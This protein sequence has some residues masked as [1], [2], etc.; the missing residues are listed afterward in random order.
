[1]LF[2]F[3]GL[4][5][6]FAKTWLTF[7]IASVP[8]ITGNVWATIRTTNLMS[9]VTLAEWA[10]LTVAL[11]VVGCISQLGMKPGYM[12]EV[13]DIGKDR[14][15]SALKSATITLSITG[16]I[17][18]IALVFVFFILYKLTFWENILAVFIL[19]LHCVLTNAVMMFHTDLRIL[20]KASLLAR[21]S[22]FQIPVF[23]CFLEICL[24]YQLDP[25]SSF[26]FSGCCSNILILVFLVHK[27]KIKNISNFDLNFINKATSMGLP[28]M[29]GLLARYSCDFVVVATF[30]WAVDNQASG[31]FGIATRLCEP[32]M[33]VYIGS[34]QMAWGS[35]I[36]Q[37]IKKSPKGH[38]VST[39][40]N[41][42][43]LLV[44]FGVPI[45]LAIALCIWLISF[46]DKSFDTVYLFVLMLISRIVS[47]GMSSSMGFGQTMQR[48]YKQGLKINL[49]ELS[50]T[51]ILVP[52]SAVYF[53]VSATLIL[54]G[55]LPWLSVFRTRS[56]S[57]KILLKTSL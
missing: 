7:L 36:Y 56:Y 31:S 45:G 47:F 55:I 29:G 48:S 52:I 50:L 3:F 20:G 33:A 49:T 44:I 14:R 9:N 57:K 53:G 54:C 19:P 24:I 11:T 4:K 8:V 27:S 38:L 26:F 35:H 28:V 41:R 22:I 12:Q 25:L 34:F 39:Y 6:S 18:G 51:L 21:L 17:G 2:N 42:S 40:S 5:S 37:W 23:I 1:M 15:L 30:R 16:L 10:I 32:L 46:S 13:S 43:W